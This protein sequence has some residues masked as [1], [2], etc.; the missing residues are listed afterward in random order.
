MIAIGVQLHQTIKP[1]REQSVWL[2][3][4]RGTGHLSR[5]MN[6][7]HLP[8]RGVIRLLKRQGI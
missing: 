1:T 5:F 7:L 6:L 3:R 8:K 4:G 2:R